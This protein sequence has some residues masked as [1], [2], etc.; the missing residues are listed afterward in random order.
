M[1]SKWLTAVIFKLAVHVRGILIC[2]HDTAKWINQPQIFF[3][4]SSLEFVV[5]PFGVN[6]VWDN[7]CFDWAKNFYSQ[8]VVQC[9]LL[10]G[11]RRKRGKRSGKKSTNQILGLS[12]FSQTVVGGDNHITHPTSYGWSHALG[13][14][15]RELEFTFS[16]KTIFLDKKPPIL[17]LKAGK[18]SNWKFRLI[19]DESWKFPSGKVLQKIS[20]FIIC[21]QTSKFRIQKLFSHRIWPTISILL[22]NF[23]IWV[24]PSINLNK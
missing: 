20:Y 11:V 15:K 21:A 9:Q 24:T 14:S 1:R 23:R 7:L 10:F 19:N 5:T 16:V 18:I 2:A 17:F 6:L 13:S 12:S 4:T 8:R 3:L 22:L